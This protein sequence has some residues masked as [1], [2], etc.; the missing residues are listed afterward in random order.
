MIIA[1]YKF[2]SGE[3]ISL[4]KDEPNYMVECWDNKNKSR[5]LKSYRNEIEARKEFERMQ[6]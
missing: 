2:S 6:A 5:W 1:E 4:I 3:T